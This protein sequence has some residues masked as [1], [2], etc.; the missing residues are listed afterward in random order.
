MDKNIHHAK[1]PK[2]TKIAAIRT[3]NTDYNSVYG[4]EG[5]T[6]PKT[7]LPEWA[8]ANLKSGEKVEALTSDPEP[9]RMPNIYQ[10]GLNSIVISYPDIF[11]NQC[12]HVWSCVVHEQ[13]NMA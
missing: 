4:E 5:D 8:D 12:G 7:V 6:G 9:S 11:L 13:K 1:A 3:I 2:G 10:V